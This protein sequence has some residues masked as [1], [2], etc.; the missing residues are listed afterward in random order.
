MPSAHQAYGQWNPEFFED[1]AKS[2]GPYTL[3]YIQQL[4]TQF[5]YPEIAYKQC[6]GILAFQRTYDCQRLENASK[7]A[8]QYPKA[9]YHTIASILK[10]RLDMEDLPHEQTIIIGEHTNIRGAAHYQ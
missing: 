5:R 6:Q 2:I 7:R 9:S 3:Q 10:S 4:L 1:K 8:L